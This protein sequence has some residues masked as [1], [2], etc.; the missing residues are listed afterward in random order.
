MTSLRG[1]RIGGPSALPGSF[2]SPVG[3]RSRCACAG[4]RLSRDATGTARIRWM[5]V[6]TIWIS[7]GFKDCDGPVGTSGHLTDWLAIQRIGVPK[8]CWRSL[9][10]RWQGDAS[11]Q[12]NHARLDRRRRS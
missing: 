10:R 8:C 4:A 6:K 11:S 12:E 2:T 7:R 3:R 9:E 5:S 1:R